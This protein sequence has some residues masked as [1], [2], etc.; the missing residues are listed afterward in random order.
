MTTRTR[1]VAIAG[2]AAALACASAAR[3][4]PTARAVL[5]RLAPRST[6]QSG[7]FPPCLC[8]VLLS[9]DLSGTFRLRLESVDPLFWHYSV[10][11]VDWA[12]AFGGPADRR[13]T[14][15]GQYR[16]GGEV[17][18]TNQMTLDLSTN[19]ETP[20]HFDSGLVVTTALFPK[21]DVTVSINGAFCHDTVIHIVAS[22]VRPAADLNGDNVVDSADLALLLGM[23]GTQD[24]VG[25]LNGD[26]VVD[27]A[28]LAMM[29]GEWGAP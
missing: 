16:I 12:A 1:T 11:E 8:P 4:Q 7:C 21:I 26:G 22:P 29:L 24:E 2:C 6:Y 10:S 13:L 18:N 28:D 17:A 15:G 5:Y 3:G 19:G 27:S 9:A 25:D 14:G 20:E 23:W